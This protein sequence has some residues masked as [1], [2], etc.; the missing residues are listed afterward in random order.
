MSDL[1]TLLGPIVADIVGKAEDLRP[2][3]EEIAEDLA[4]IVADDLRYDRDELDA[5]VRVLV[6]V[7]SISARSAVDWSEVGRILT[8]VLRAVIAGVVAL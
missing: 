2:I 7:A 8:Y 3:A 4:S 5:Q 1:A 6:E